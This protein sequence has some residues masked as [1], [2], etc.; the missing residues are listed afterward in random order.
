[1]EEGVRQVVSIYE[2]MTVL[3]R[4]LDILAGRM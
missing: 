2:E 4:L 1:V 3:Y